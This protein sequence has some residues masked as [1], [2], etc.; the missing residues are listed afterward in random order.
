M[1]RCRYV[2]KRKLYD[3]LLE[4]KKSHKHECL[5][6]TGQ[7]QVGKTFIIDLFGKEQYSHYIYVAFS[8]NSVSS[9]YFDGDLDVNTILNRMSIDYRINDLVPGDTLFFFDEIQ[10]CP[11]AYS[12]LKSFAIDGRFDVIASGSMLGTAMADDPKYISPLG[13]VRSLTLYS[14]DFEEFLWARGISPQ[15][16][17]EVRDCIKTCKELNMVFYTRIRDMFRDFMLTGGMPEAVQTFVDTGDFSKAHDVLEKIYNNAL[18]DINRYNRG[19]DRLR[20]QDCFLSIPAQ[21]AETNKRFKYSRIEGNTNRRGFERYEGN[22]FWIKGAGYGNFCYCL[23]E[24]G[25]IWNYYPDNFKVY[26]SDTGLLMHMYG[27]NVRSK[28]YSGEPIKEKG[29]VFENIVAE[30]IMK[31]GYPLR[32]YRNDKGEMRMEID[33]VLDFKEKPAAV[34]VKS[35][36]DRS[37]PSLSKVTR[38]FSVR[39]IML[40]DSN[41]YLDKN[42]IEHYP[43]FAAAFID[44]ME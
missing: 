10:E 9:N 4:W 21:L 35:G 18:R 5:M 31:C 29:A 32:Y 42:N 26:M 16:I 41:I 6:V 36:A 37:A 8:M 20:V 3:K 15:V 22:L 39:R 12:S 1:G 19:G 11:A 13:Y 2:L 30:C 7:R 24:L 34:E 33:F 23:K 38:F 17:G 44:S 40:E 25:S 14:L 43:L 28:L 27:H